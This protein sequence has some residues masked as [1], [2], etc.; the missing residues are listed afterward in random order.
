MQGSKFFLS[1]QSVRK[2][3]CV[4]V[5]T[6]SFG[7]TS[8]EDGI[9]GKQGFGDAYTKAFVCSTVWN[10]LSKNE[11]EAIEKVQRQADPMGNK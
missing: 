7:E 4:G 3:L 1:H 6:A 5:I 2:I 9:K 10:S 11:S 8:L